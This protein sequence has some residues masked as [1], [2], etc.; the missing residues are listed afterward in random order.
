MTSLAL[1]NVS[2]DFNLPCIDRSGNENTPTLG[3]RDSI[4]FKNIMS[5][6]G[7]TQIDNVISNSLI[8]KLSRFVF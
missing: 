7:H 6:I 2:V 3:S 5:E 1:Y 4:L 8:R